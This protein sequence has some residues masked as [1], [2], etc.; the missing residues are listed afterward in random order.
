MDN[1]GAYDRELS[2]FR[3]K[4]SEN[5]SIKII[6]SRKLEAKDLED[7]PQIRLADEKKDD[8]TR[9]KYVMIM[10][11]CHQDLFQYINHSG[12]AGTDGE[13]SFIEQMNILR[14]IAK[15]LIELLSNLI[16]HGDIKPRN[17]LLR[18]GQPVLCD[19]DNAVQIDGK[20]F[21]APKQTSTGYHPPEKALIDDF[22]NIKNDVESMDG[23]EK[24]E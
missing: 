3:E 18:E 12:H 6:D 21:A 5:S 11:K 16:S 24:E 10:E 22:E 19:Y 9:L 8:P 13:T 2:S 17:V 20:T 15:C 1:K 7:F 4:L 14:G 23:K